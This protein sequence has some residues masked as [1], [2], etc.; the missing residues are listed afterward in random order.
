LRAESAQ[1]ATANREKAA[2]ELLSQAMEKDLRPEDENRV[3]ELEEKI[4]QRAFQD[5]G[6]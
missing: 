3:R 1:A 2:L 5:T 4:K 6:L